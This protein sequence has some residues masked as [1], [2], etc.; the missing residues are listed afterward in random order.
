MIFS[1]VHYSG[2]SM[3]LA[4]EIMALAKTL[5]PISPKQ[6]LWCETEHYNRVVECHSKAQGEKSYM[7]TLLQ[8][9]GDWQILRN[10]IQYIQLRNRGKEIVVGST[11]ECG[12]TFLNV[13][14]G[15]IGYMSRRL[16]CDGRAIDY[17]KP[18]I[19]RRREEWSNSFWLYSNEGLVIAGSRLHPLFRRNG[20][21]TKM[22][23]RSWKDREVKKWSSVLVMERLISNPVYETLIKSHLWK[24]VAD[25]V[26]V[27][28]IG[29]RPIMLMLRNKLPLKAG[30]LTEWRDAVSMMEQE[31]IDWRN[32][33]ILKD[34]RKWHD[35]AVARVAKRKA[36]NEVRKFKAL[37]A[38]FLEVHSAHIGKGWNDGELMYH[39]LSSVREYYEEGK[40]MHH[41][42]YANKYYERPESI[43]I[44]VR[45][46]GRREATVE[47]N[48]Q[49]RKIVQ[50]RAVC[51]GQSDY[52]DEIENSVNKN[53]EKVLAE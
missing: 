17:S 8:V 52:Q 10:F 14:S 47:Y 28:N 37:E 21:S 35:V 33:K 40:A 36:E 48:I 42:V 18:M 30:E 1:V 20:L 38:K 22:I 45:I 53:I 43:I 12:R 32:G 44:S 41:C 3:K 15:K 6:Q 25:C 2:S 4:D 5:G 24:L 16:R 9:R 26:E 29:L 51:N 7:F 27:R 39:V 31:H 11:L 46:G 34:W 19:V 13:K 50:I 23:Y 49:S